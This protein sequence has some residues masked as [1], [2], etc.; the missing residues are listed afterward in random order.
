M[1]GFLIRVAWPETT[2]TIV[3]CE[4]YKTIIGVM[5]EYRTRTSK[6]ETGFILTLNATFKTEI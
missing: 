3:A 2:H 5:R 4:K 1:S 6:I